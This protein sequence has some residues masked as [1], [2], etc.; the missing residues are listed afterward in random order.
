MSDLVIFRLGDTASLVVESQE[1]V[2]EGAEHDMGLFSGR[3]VR[4]ADESLEKSMGR[5]IPA[6]RAI[7]ESITDLQADEV[8]I[9]FGLKLTAEAGIT[10][11]KTALEGHMQVTV[12]WRR[13]DLGD[14][15]ESE[16][17]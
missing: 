11:A 6:A 4:E 3:R 7:L 13:K 9:E 14:G 16:H 12:N 15:Q 1:P 5:F 10:V 2:A 17:C 8:S